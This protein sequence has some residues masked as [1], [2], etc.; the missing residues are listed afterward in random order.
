[1][2]VFDKYPKSYYKNLSDEQRQIKAVL[3]DMIPMNFRHR[4]TCGLFDLTYTVEDK[5]IVKF[6]NPKSTRNDLRRI[7][8]LSAVL[9]NEKSITFELPDMFGAEYETESGDTIYAVWYEK[10]NGRVLDRQNMGIYRG[11]DMPQRRELDAFMEQIGTFMAQLHSVP[12]MEVAHLFPQSA[13]GQIRQ[14]VWSVLPQLKTA[15]KSFRRQVEEGVLFAVYPGYDEVLC[16]N[17]LNL[18][19]I[20]RREDNTIAGIFDL[21]MANIDRPVREMKYWDYFDEHVDIIARAYR[22]KRGVSLDARNE[23]CPSAGNKPL[24]L[25]ILNIYDKICRERS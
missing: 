13:P 23:A 18:W 12:V 5:Y 14:A 17:D 22:R 4:K 24:P 7:V 16:H 25:M 15:D 20:A 10:I 9:R 3:G 21:G 1:M 8:A 6:E 19:N 2:S 11:Y